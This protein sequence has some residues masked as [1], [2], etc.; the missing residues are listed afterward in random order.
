MRHLFIAV[1]F[2][3]AAS[4]G[5]T[6][7]QS[8]SFCGKPG[9]HPGCEKMLKEFEANSAENNTQD[10][11]LTGSAT[12]HAHCVSNR[13]ESMSGLIKLWKLKVAAL[14]AKKDPKPE[15]NAANSL[16]VQFRNVDNAFQRCMQ[17]PL[18]KLET[19]SLKTKF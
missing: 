2:F 4:S 18:H 15:F 11:A 16:W 14:K 1:C 8:D 10:T 3:F 12:S 17:S 5:A 6:Y 7:A 9:E 13:K 19:P